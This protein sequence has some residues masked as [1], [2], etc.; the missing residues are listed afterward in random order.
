[1]AGMREIINSDKKVIY[2]SEVGNS[3]YDLYKKAKA[4]L[5]PIQWE[6]PFGLV[7]IEALATG[8]PVLAYNFGSVPEIIEEGRS[9]FIFDND[10]IALA[11]GIKLANI[12]D[13]SNCRKRAMDFS[14]EIMAKNYA[15]FF[16]EIIEYLF[17]PF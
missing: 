17:N 3:K 6:E 10:V 8:T 11:N 4:L 9:G 5:F 12:I 2:C 13:P 1:S 14:M 16:E 7:M 15:D